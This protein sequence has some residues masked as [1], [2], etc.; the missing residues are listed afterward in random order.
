MST[1]FSGNCRIAVQVAGISEQGRQ[2]RGSEM[3]VVGECIRQSHAAHNH[4]RCAIHDSS[5]SRFTT[6]VGFPGKAPIFNGRRN[7]FATAF[8]KVLQLI[9]FVAVGA[10]SGSVSAFQQGERRRDQRYRLGERSMK[11]RLS[12]QMPLVGG[13]TALRCRG[14]PPSWLVLVVSCGNIALTGVK[15]PT[16]KC[17][18]VVQAGRELLGTNQF[19]LEHDLTSFRELDRLRGPEDPVFI[20]CV[21]GLHDSCLRQQ[22]NTSSSHRITMYSTPGRYRGIALHVGG[23]VLTSCAG[24]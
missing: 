13:L 19:R 10:A 11:C 21:N 17:I 14:K 22:E 20:D 9:G 8:E 23:A 2:P 5:I 1:A 12:G 3:V 18:H 6:A 15:A 16:Q 7:E 24:I 4:E